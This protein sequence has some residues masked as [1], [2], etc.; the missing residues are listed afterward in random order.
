MQYVTETSYN[1]N[2]FLIELCRIRT[3]IVKIYLV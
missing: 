2:N 1:M 3:T